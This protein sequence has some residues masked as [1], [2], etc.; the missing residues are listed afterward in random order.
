MLAFNEGKLLRLQMLLAESAHQPSQ[1]KTK[2]H[3]SLVQLLFGLCSFLCSRGTKPHLLSAGLLRRWMSS[4]QWLCNP[5]PKPGEQGGC[6][7]ASLTTPAQQYLPQSAR[8]GL[9]AN[10]Q[11]ATGP[12]LSTAPY[13]STALIKSN[14][15]GKDMNMSN[16]D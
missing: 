7:P 10:S 4:W 9:S 1:P 16:C 5:P 11:C 2:D 15:L 13:K 14:Y 6:S 8:S 3:V 12:L